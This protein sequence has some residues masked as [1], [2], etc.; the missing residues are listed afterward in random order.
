MRVFLTGGT[1][2]VGGYLCDALCAEGHEVVALARVPRPA[3]PGITWVRGEIGDADLL[4]EAMSGCDAVI[5]LIGIIRER[6]K[7][8]FQ[9]M[10][11]EGTEHILEAMRANGIMRLLH[12]SALGASAKSQTAY[13]RTKW[14]AEER[15]RAAG[16][17]HTIFRPSIIFGPGDGF[18][19]LLARQ[20]RRF[21]VIPIIGSGAYPFAPISIHAVAAAFTQALRLNGSTAGKTFELCGPEV[22]TYE[23]IID[24]LMAHMRVRKLKA[25]L[26]EAL[27]R[28]ITGAVS[29]AH[30]PSPITRDQLV[31][32]LDGNVCAEQCAREV[33]TLPEITLAEGIRDYVRG[34][35]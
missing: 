5:H 10:H 8:T 24:L 22:L 20:I 31:M 2:F 11:V 28:F 18:I 33:F 26:P 29:I 4:A 16:L 15:V 6:G 1:G 34:P 23:Q 14:E 3:R 7:V 17:T 30:L 21:P 35:A 32:L 27:M 19:S 13:A 12:M 25:H 9:A